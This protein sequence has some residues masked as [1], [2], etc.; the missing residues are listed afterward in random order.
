[1]GNSFVAFDFETANS[2]R[3]SACEIGMV[4]VIDGLPVAWM[5]SLIS[6]HADHAEFDYM[7]T[8]LHGIS[9]EDVEGSPEFDAVWDEAREFIGDLPL[10]AHNASFDIRVLRE[11]FQLYSLPPV[12]LTYFCTLVLSR[13][14]L[15]LV[16]YSLP[17]VA[18]ELNVQ[19]D[20]H[21]RASLDALA[22]AEIASKLVHRSGLDDLAELA[23]SLRV[24]AGHFDGE[25][26]LSSQ[27]R[28]S[29]SSNSAFNAARIAELRSSLGEVAAKA[30][31]DGPL[32]GRRVAFTGGLASLTRAEA[33]ARVLAVG[34]EPQATVNKHT[35]FLVI[36]AEN[37][38]A[39]DPHTAATAKFAKAEALRAK[40]SEIEILDEITFLRML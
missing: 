14:A 16:S 17:F 31:P 1:M 35:N 25:V 6:P 39:I 27:S 29:G 21:H 30:D 11:L 19:L 4:R 18:K 12:N 13:K 37:G 22:T 10:V 3:G 24:M 20:S 7:N 28:S 5:E 40:G 23:E 26:V 36:G 2:Y 34:G 38:Y 33:A 8:S 9:E 32:F 15:D